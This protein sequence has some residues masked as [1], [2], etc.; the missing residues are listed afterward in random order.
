[1]KGFR[2]IDR[3]PTT[4]RDVLIIAAGVATGVCGA[5]ALWPFLGTVTRGNLLS[6]RDDFQ[7]DLSGIEPGQ[8]ILA[9][10]HNKP[11]L[12]R[13][14]TP[15]EIAELRSVPLHMLIDPLARNP[16]LPD[17]T[18]AYDE[19]RVKP[20]HD[21]WL[22]VLGLCTHLGCGLGP[23]QPQG[24]YGGWFCPCHGAH[25]DAAGRARKGPA[26]ENLAIPGYKFLS[27]TLIEIDRD[28]G[29]S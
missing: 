16:D 21:E 5:A 25:F 27:E 4:R 8:G 17:D 11:V 15:V 19:N 20:E 1:M 28:S 9:V 24:E 10:H 3:E 29:S 13:R 6:W 22:V 2:I 12:V 23:N 18:P 14:R 26:P 7:I